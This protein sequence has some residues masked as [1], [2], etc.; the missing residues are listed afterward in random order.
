MRSQC[1]GPR[2]SAFIAAAGLF[3][4]ARAI[5][6]ADNLPAGLRE[7]QE[8]A[9]LTDV[10]FP[11]ATHGW[12]VGD[13]GT[14]YATNDAGKHWRLQPAR[15]ECRLASVQFL[16]ADNGWAAGGSFF[17]YTHTSRGL[18]L[19]TRDGGRSWAEDKGLMLP[20]LK[21]TKFFNPKLGWAF[22]ESSALFS[23]GIF[24][25]DNG[26][27]TWSPVE[28]RPASGW[29]AADF[30]DAHAG[31][32]AG[33]DGALAAIRRRGLAPART[34]NFGWRSLN[35]MRFSAETTGWLV[36]DGGLVLATAD[37]GLSW[38]TPEADPTELVGNDFDWQALEVRGER[39]WIAGSPGSKILT[40]DDGGKH[41]HAFATD[42]NLPLY[43]LSFADNLHGW[44]VGALGTIL[45]TAD[46]GRTWQRQR[47]G[48][49]RAAVLAL[50]QQAS[51]VP[52][53]LL[54]RLS[55]NDGY[56][57]AVEVLTRRGPDGDRFAA[58][59][60]ERNHAALVDAGASAVH[61]A[62][63]FP[64]PQ[65]TAQSAE[66]I[67][68]VWN[69]LYDGEG[70]EQVEAFLVRKIRCWRP[71]IVVT[72]AA[73]LNG[74]DPHGHVVNQLVLQAV[75]QAADPTC[76]PEQLSQMGLAAWKARKVFG[77]LPGGQLGDVNVSTAQLAQRLG[78]SLADYVTGPRGLMAEDYAGSPANVGF[79]LY[80]DTLP[81]H[82]G[83]H[84]FFSGITLHPGGEARRNIGEYSTPGIDVLRRMAQKQRNVQAI[85]TRAEQGQ[86]DSARYAAQ[87]NDLTVGLD[88]ST[89][90]NV[91]Y[92]LGQHYR[93]TGK[94]PLAAETFTMLVERHPGHPLAEAALVWLVRYWSSGEAAWR[95]RR[96]AAANGQRAAAA[97][98]ASQITVFQPPAALGQV[99]PAK[100]EIAAG[101][102][103]RVEGRMSVAEHTLEND[104]ASRAIA[105]GKLLE[106]RNPATYAEPNVRFSLASAYRQQG[107]TK[108][109]QKHYLDVAHLRDHDDWWACAAGEHWLHAPKDVAPKSILR[110]SSGPRPRLD[111][112]LD[113]AI[114]QRTNTAELKGELSNAK[115]LPA[116]ATLAYD[117]EFLYLA[118]ECRRSIAGP[119]TSEG[120]RPRD[121]DLGAH[122]RVDF[123]FDLDR[124]WSTWYRLTVDHRGWTG[125]ACFDDAAWNPEWYVAAGGD[126]HAWTVEAAIPLAELA[127]ERPQPRYVWAL[128]IER[129]IPGE[130]VQSWTIPVSAPAR[131]ESFGYLIFE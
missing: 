30:L 125:E 95:E 13:R 93:Q 79:R 33:R 85:I 67:V 27:R 94:W 60:C 112:R 39:V 91:I 82:V 124:D 84:D 8:D 2:L 10:D 70:I 12:A 26:G 23:A 108:D 65:S 19:R 86:L 61:T 105:L 72:H 7:M 100:N 73:C 48:G 126:D 59:A 9:E 83:E 32:I 106:Q 123:F 5:V 42:Q 38:Q 44:A 43:S 87:I 24:V 111:G 36:G 46:G 22:G 118:V 1:P 4:A 41:W 15:V 54:A 115:E 40:S 49:T 121:P 16:D 75:E 97:Q 57:A 53:E 77:S 69:R 50:Y 14:I 52:L 63:N 76:F 66:E 99:L 116:K 28:G 92:Q 122:D 62:S 114:W 11:D 78:A 58:N 45:A 34:P 68:D 117:N 89:A 107:L 81:Q 55:G 37:A 51:D 31:A 17:P 128:G 6:A 113:D 129:T 74:D 20:A 102:A 64:L 130:G 56:L 110:V 104:R 18:L 71:E 25:T 101:N 96:L 109:A 103:P 131:P 29:L 98:I 35:R 88:A 3:L 120:P 90:G 127:G 21:K 47:S 119:A 80:V